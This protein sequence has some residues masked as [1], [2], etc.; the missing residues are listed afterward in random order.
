[1]TGP[2]TPATTATSAANGS[3]TGSIYDIGYR[4]YEGPRF[5][6]AHAIRSLFIH[7]VRSSFGLGRGGRAKI[8]PVILGILALLPAVL[9][10]GALTLFAQFAVGDQVGDEFAAEVPIRYDTYAGTI[11]TI[12]VLFCAAQAPELFGRDQRHGVL[13]LYF[14]RALRRADYALARIGGFVTALLILE[15]LPQIVLFLGRVLLSPDIP[16]GIRDDLPS[17]GPVLAQSAL[18]AALL[19]GLA[20]AV[21]AFTPRRAYAVAGIIA[22]FIIP[23]VVAGVVTALGS[24]TI[25]TWLVLTSPTTVLDGTN[26]FLFDTRLDTDFFFID[27]PDWSFL[28]AA[29]VGIAGSLAITLRRFARITA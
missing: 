2:T 19:G 28:A 18:S 14:A 7:S 9:I 13:A 4:R 3:P 23:N 27:L 29:A 22:L 21:S 20:M 17:F 16:R 24:S 8:A 5:G 12:V 10:V 11:S 25:G 26:A 1:M 6:R 15:L